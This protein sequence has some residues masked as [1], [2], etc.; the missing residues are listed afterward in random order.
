M[1]RLDG[2]SIR[3]SLSAITHSRLDALDVFDEIAST[4]SFLMQQSP[5]A[6]GHLRVAVT[7][8]Q[9]Q[10]RGR[11]GRTWQSPPGSGLCLSLAHAFAETPE[12]LP[13][14]TLAIGLGVIDALEQQGIR[15]VQLKWPNDLIAGDGKLGGILTE[16]HAH[17]AEGICV[18]TGVGLNI[19]IGRG[20]DVDQPVAD[21]ASLAAATPSGNVLAA[22]LIDVLCD[23]FVD[24][25]ISG[26]T[27][28]RDRWSARD[29]LLGRAVIIDAPGP[30]TSGIGAGIDA[31]GALLLD[32]A[33]GV[34]RVSSGS[35]MLAPG[36]GLVP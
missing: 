5:P 1:S 33:A 21:L 30:E 25:A 18:V 10:G 20:L 7:D 17:G 35:V 29:W 2:Q 23:T 26:F 15:G 11:H 13:A 36:D 31:D 14:L 32:T 34:V 22:R 4:N 28:F 6:P 9:T 19:D 27:P 12:D 24:Y 8:N 16:T 3:R